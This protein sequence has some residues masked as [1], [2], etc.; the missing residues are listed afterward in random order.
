MFSVHLYE[1]KMPYC[2]YMV[3]VG[4]YPSMESYD[5]YRSSSLA[6]TA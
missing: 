3:M 4:G 2:P 6:G 5:A 1:Y